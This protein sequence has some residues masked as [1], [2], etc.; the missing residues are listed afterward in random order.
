MT[1]FAFLRGRLGPLGLAA[2]LLGAGAARADET[3]GHIA[4][5]DASLVASVEQI[6]RA[7]V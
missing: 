1:L 5:P 4:S 2:M 6:G 7:H 3:I